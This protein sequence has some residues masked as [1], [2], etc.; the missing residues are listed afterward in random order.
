MHRS[1]KAFFIIFFSII[2]IVIAVSFCKYFIFKDYYIKA[3]VPC[4]PEQENC[5]MVECDPII[6]SECPENTSERVSYYKIV[7]KKAHDIPLCDSDFPDCLP[8][9][10]QEKEKCKE[11][12]CDE[13]NKPEGVECS[14][15]NILR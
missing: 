8:F 10:C 1:S 5:F 14:N 4:N 11:I 2:F 12:L 9:I 15:S 6:D 3:E 13:S 7:E